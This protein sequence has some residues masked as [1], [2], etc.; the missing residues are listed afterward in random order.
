MIRLLTQGGIRLERCR[1]ERG[2]IEALIRAGHPDLEVLCLAMADWAEEERLMLQEA[3]LKATTR[4]GVRRAGRK[5]AVRTSGDKRVDAF[6]V[7]PLCGG[8]DEES[9]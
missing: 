4:C 1:R 3:G 6:A 5:G 9:T 2:A 7:L 8:D